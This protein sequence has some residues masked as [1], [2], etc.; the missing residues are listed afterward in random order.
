MTAMTTKPYEK[1]AMKV[2]KLQNQAPLVCASTRD[3]DFRDFSNYEG[4]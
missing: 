1:P 4:D 3:A 2:V